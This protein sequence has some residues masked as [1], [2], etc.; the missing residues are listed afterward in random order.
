[1]EW[2]SACPNQDPRWPV[3]PHDEPLPHGTVRPRGPSAGQSGFCLS[4]AVGLRGP[5]NGASRG[6]SAGQSEVGRSTHFSFRTP[7]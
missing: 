1:M 6:S 2:F 7:V 3:L 4:V 5:G